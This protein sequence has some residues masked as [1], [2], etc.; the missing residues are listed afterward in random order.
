M[1][2]LR[3]DERYESEHDGIHTW[4][5]FSAGAHYDPD[6]LSF[7]P[8]LGVD[9]HLLQPGAGFAEHA[10]R[11]V[12]IISWI[13]EGHLEHSAGG[14][15]QV[16]NPD[17]SLIQDTSEV[18]EHAERNASSTEQ[19]RLIQTTLAADSDVT[20]TVLRA[21]GELQAPWLHLFVVEGSWRFG[22]DELQPGDSVRLTDDD[23]HV[24]DGLGVLLVL[25]HPG[26]TDQS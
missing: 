12:E 14:Q 26:L 4:H 16:I 6:N 18:L 13:A 25:S 22:D 2:I 3:A 1:K 20:F 23:S 10:H 11:G 8:L 5:C 7:G 21:A 17:E 15:T 9:E 24:V 19:L